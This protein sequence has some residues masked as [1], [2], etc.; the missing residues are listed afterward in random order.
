V[1]EV[2]GVLPVGG[3]LRFV[4]TSG[5]AASEP[6]GIA[7]P[8]PTPTPTRAAPTAAPLTED[9]APRA[10]PAAPGRL[11]VPDFLVAL[12]T[13]VLVVALAVGQPSWR[14]QDPVRRLR[15]PLLAAAGGWLG[16]LTLDLALGLGWLARGG[17]R[18]PHLDAI[19]AVAAGALTA[20]VLGLAVERATARI[21]RGRR[22]A[23]R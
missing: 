16:Y 6:V 17:R 8:Q 20:A 4:A 7:L 3:R 19:A 9:G 14:R 10:T 21:R 22:A 5:G 23:A 11:G 13:V 1:A 12:A 15:A 2:A 18:V